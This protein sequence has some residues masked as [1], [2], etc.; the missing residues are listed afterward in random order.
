MMLVEAEALCRYVL[1]YRASPPRTR[2]IGTAHLRYLGPWLWC[3][4][5]TVMGPTVGLIVG[6]T[7]GIGVGLSGVPTV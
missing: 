5:P 7:M 3:T 1:C 6:L 2:L 4:L